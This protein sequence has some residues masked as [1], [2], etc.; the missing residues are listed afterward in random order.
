LWGRDDEVVRVRSSDRSF[1][2]PSAGFEETSLLIKHDAELAELKMDEVGACVAEIE[3]LSDGRL[4]N[5]MHFPWDRGVEDVAT[6][7]EALTS[8]LGPY[9][10]H[11]TPFDR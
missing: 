6:R 4:P 9:F 7:H 8:I 1:D 11:F 10:T 3:V 2:Q 5:G